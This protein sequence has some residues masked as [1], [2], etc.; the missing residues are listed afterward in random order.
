MDCELTSGFMTLLLLIVFIAISSWAWGGGQ[1]ER[2]DAAARIPLDDDL[3]LPESR[4]QREER[5]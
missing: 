1:R 2:F 5:K 4:A 3:P